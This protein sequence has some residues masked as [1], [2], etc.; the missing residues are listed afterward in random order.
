MERAREGA[1]MFRIAGGAKTPERYRSTTWAFFLVV[2]ILI[3]ASISAPIYAYFGNW[4]PIGEKREIW[5]QRSGAVT[6][7]FSFMAA[8]MIVFTSGRLHTP[9]FFGSQ[10]KLE[11]LV[12]FKNYFRV[13][14]ALIFVLSI[15]GTVVWGYGDIIYLRYLD[16]A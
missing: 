8:S 10:V 5:I 13:A 4:L 9:G 1:V 12:E 14:E 7:L 16:P 3:A 15:I 11:I 6:T 2:V